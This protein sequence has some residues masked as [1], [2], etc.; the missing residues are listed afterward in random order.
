[1]RRGPPDLTPSPLLPS[2]SPCG[3]GPGVRGLCSGMFNRCHSGLFPLVIPD[4]SHPVIP[5][6]SLPVI[7]DVINRE[8]KGRGEGVPKGAGEARPSCEAPTTG[9]KEK[10]SGFPLTDGGNDKRGEAGRQVRERA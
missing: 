8:S 1:M 2:L 10:D 9:Q 3:R 5:D 4:V 6:V 7:P